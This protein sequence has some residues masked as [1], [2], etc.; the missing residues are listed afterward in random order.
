MNLK[1]INKR[2]YLP[3]LLIYFNIF[4]ETFDICLKVNWLLETNELT[5]V[6]YNWTQKAI[7]AWF[8]SSANLGVTMMHIFTTYWRQ[9]YF[10]FDMERKN[11]IFDELSSSLS[12]Q[13]DFHSS[14]FYI[15]LYLTAHII[16]TFIIIIVVPDFD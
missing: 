16:I 1:K 4:S 8:T 11:V 13:L 5:W 3:I 14:D 10:I 9:Q 2:I 15:Y 12:S 6:K 7:S